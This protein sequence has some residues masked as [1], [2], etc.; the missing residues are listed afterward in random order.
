MSHSTGVVVIGR[1]DGLRLHA[2]LS[3]VKATG[4][5]LVY[6][7]SGSTDDSR[8]T[9][10]SLSVRVHSLDPDRPFSA[11]RG[12]NEGFMQLLEEHPQLDS[13]LFLDG[14]CT[15]DEH[16]IP[17][18]TAAL[19]A[20]SR[21]ALVCSP[22]R[23]LDPQRD[24]W[25]LLCDL[26]WDLPVGPIEHCGG[27]FLIRTK[28]YREIGGMDAGIIAGEEPEMCLQLKRLNWK[29]LRIPEGLVIHDVGEFN[30]HAWWVRSRRSG[31]AFLLGFLRDGFSYNSQ[32]LRE[33]LRPWFWGLSL[34]LIALALA[35]LH[36][37]GALLLLLLPMHLA[38]MILRL[39]KQGRSW[40]EARIFSLFNLLGRWAEIAGHLRLLSSILAGS[41][42]S[43]RGLRNS[44]VVRTQTTP[45]SH[46]AT[47]G[48]V[49]VVVIGRNEGERLHACLRSIVA[50]SLRVIY[51]DSGSTDDSTQFARQ[52]GVEVVDLDMNTPFTAARARNAG[53]AKLSELEPQMDFVQFVDGD[54]TVD[55]TW[56]ATAS[57]ALLHN[58]GVVAVSGRRREQFPEAS[59][60]NRLADFEWDTPLGPIK[61][62]GG[63]VLMRARA[64]RE[65]NGY[66]S[67]L[68]A[69]EEPELCFRLRTR[70]WTILRIDAEMTRHDADITCFSQWWTRCTRTGYSYLQAYSLH[71][72]EPGRFLSQEIR[73]AGI[74]GAAFPLLL[75][76]S[77][78]EPLLIALA[79]LMILIQAKRINR[80]YEG[81]VLAPRFAF[82]AIL[83]NLPIA[84]GML[85][86]LRFRLM[87]KQSALIEYK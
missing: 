50:T 51:V 12:R 29:L 85:R 27:I 37:S 9:A 46:N 86:Y 61:W 38:R 6:V 68:I 45:D 65:V 63:D 23:E 79:G 19:I 28:A 2:C 41:A 60:Y 57:K 8:M 59:A 56:L 62:C 32:N 78:F 71:R 7:D 67:E 30:F 21:M 24:V 20:D 31:L 44:P 52:L 16:V 11:A 33:T 13:I 83:I 17:A 1:N 42:P 25:K 54:C 82:F 73:S 5:P 47:S 84:V 3:S 55:S 4:C 35:L 75:F 74:W 10:E 58:P 53:F 15:I 66:N 14:D 72:R 48:Q 43:P 22:V 40:R 76:A 36:P 26:E 69:C 81:K 39:H 70:G 18:G 80:R 49:G 64:L 77:A 87:G 34:P